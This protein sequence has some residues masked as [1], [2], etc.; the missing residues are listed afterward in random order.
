MLHIS[1]NMATELAVVLAGIEGVNPL[2][3]LLGISSH[4]HIQISNETVTES[5]MLPC[6]HRDHNYKYKPVSWLPYIYNGYP[7]T[8]KIGVY[9]VF[10]LHI[11]DSESGKHWFR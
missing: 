5:M 4:D 3:F 11:W 10:M 1:Q 6:H 2:V 9:I 8:W 7:Y